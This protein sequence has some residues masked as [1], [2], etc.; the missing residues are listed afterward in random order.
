LTFAR[1][2]RARDALSDNDMRFVVETVGDI[3]DDIGERIAEEQ[4]GHEEETEVLVSPVPRIRILAA[5]ASDEVDRLS[6]LMLRNVLDPAKWQVDVTGA[7]TLSAELVDRVENESRVC[8]CIG[9][10]PPGGLA[11]ARYLCKRLH[12]R[13]PSARI[14]VGRWGLRGNVEESEMQLQDAGAES[15]D[16]TLAET[17]KE[18]ESW[19]LFLAQQES[20]A[21]AN[22]AV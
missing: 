1:R 4:H 8:V 10:L 3:L 18:L 22:H 9:S 21:I 20:R 12:S 7:E 11:R 2:D 5:P 6:L 17:C 13:F 19:R 15:Q 16:V 14:L